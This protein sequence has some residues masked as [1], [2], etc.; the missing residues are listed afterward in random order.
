M[1][2]ISSTTIENTQH[3]CIG[4]I[5]ATCHQFCGEI[6]KNEKK[7]RGKER[8]NKRTAQVIKDKKSL[9]PEL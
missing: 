7:M 2:A 3:L 4:N 6:L 1:L 8:E 5:R 9:R